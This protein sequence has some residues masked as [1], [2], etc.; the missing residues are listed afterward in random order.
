MKSFALLFVILISGAFGMLQAQGYRAELGAMGGVSSYMGDANSTFLKNTEPALSILGRY[1]L[2]PRF[3]LK[4]DVGYTALSGNTIGRS[5]LFPQGKELSFRNQLMDASCQM[6]FNFYE[7]GAPD[8][9]PG[10]SR[11]SPYVSTG[12]GLLVYENGDNWKTTAC[13]P[14]GIGIKYKTSFRMNI[15][16][17]LSYRI[18]FSDQLDNEASSADFQLDTPWMG[19]SAWNKNN[20]HFATLKC[21]ITYDLWY[22]GSNCYKE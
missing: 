11:I 22:I 1:H 3:S 20:D 7:Y 13:V 10:S 16:L 8:F 5:K 17:E 4:A 6:E 14:V 9:R 21:F 2:N 18:S 12:I 15:G 19:Q